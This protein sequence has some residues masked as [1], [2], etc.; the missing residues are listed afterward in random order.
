MRKTLWVTVLAIVIFT[1]MAPRAAAQTFV[2]PF[3]GATFGADAPGSELTTGV[4]LTF[5]GP[6]AGFEAELGYTPD[7]FSEDDNFDLAD[8]SN[9]T[10]LMANLMIPFSV[11]DAP[12][13]PYLTAGAGLLRSRVDGGDLFDDVR[14]NDFGFNLGFGLIGRVTEHVGIRGDVRYF[15]NVAGGEDATDADDIGGFDGFNL[16]VGQFDFW[17]AH[18]GVA[19]GF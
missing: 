2:T 3:V 18:V 1:A 11:R 16:D 4:A 7:F 15:R 14:S 9:V 6:V 5:L 12:V 8:G 19:L 13:R 17:R 10:T